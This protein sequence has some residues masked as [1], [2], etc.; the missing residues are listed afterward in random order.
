M[1]WANPGRSTPKQSPSHGSHILSTL[2]AEC[3][4]RPPFFLRKLSADCLVSQSM[5]HGTQAD[6]AQDPHRSI[7]LQHMAK[8][9]RQ[10]YQKALDQLGFLQRYWAAVRYMRSA[11][12]QNGQ[13][14]LQVTL[15]EDGM[16][17]SPTRLSDQLTEWLASASAL[18]NGD[19]ESSCTSAAH[20]AGS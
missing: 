1:V 14:I 10:N 9:S 18:G 12:L 5:N 4:V 8:L 13:G 2:L 19:R 20:Q 7:S 11:L 15:T 6:E 3:F 17:A 16:P